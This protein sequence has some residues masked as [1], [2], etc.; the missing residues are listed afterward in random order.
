MKRSTLLNQS[1]RGDGGGEDR[2]ERGLGEE[3]R[4][5]VNEDQ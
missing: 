4:E 3:G 1:E 5:A 2:G